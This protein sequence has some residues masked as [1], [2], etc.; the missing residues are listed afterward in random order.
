MST[1][2]EQITNDSFRKQL[3][4][5][6]VRTVQPFN[7]VENPAFENFIDFV[8]N[9]NPELKLPSR[10]TL[11][12]DFNTMYEEEKERLKF[13]IN[14]ND[15]KIALIID[16]WTSSNQHSF[17]GIIAQWISK[18]WEIIRVPLDLT[19]MEGSHSGKNIAE[20]VERAIAEFD[21]WGKI[22]GITTDNASN[23]DTFFEEL[24]E[25][26]SQ[27]GCQFDIKNRR[28]RCLAHILNLTTKSIRNA[29]AV[30][31]SGLVA[32]YSDDSSD[33]PLII[34]FDEDEIKINRILKSVEERKTTLGKLR[35]AIVG[36]RASP[37]RRQRFK[38]QCEV[39]GTPHKELI[40]DVPVRW[41]TSLGMMERG[42][43]LRAPLECTINTLPELT[44]FKLDHEDWDRI[45]LLIDILEPISK[46]TK[47]LSSGSAPT[48]SKCA[49]VYQDL[50]DHL[51]SF[52]E[53][54]IGSTSLGPQRN[55]AYPV[56]LQ[57]AARAGLGKL[58]KYYPSTDGLPYVAGT[59]L[60]PRCKS[61]WFKAVNWKKDWIDG[62]VRTFKNEWK[63]NY[64]LQE[65]NPPD[66]NIVDDVEFESQTLFKQM[67]G[68]SASAEE[69][70]VNRYLK[71]KPVSVA[72]MN[73][74]FEIILGWWKAHEQQF[75]R[76]SKMARD[77]LCV[78]GT[79]VPCE[80]FFSGA[81]DLLTVRR[82]R[83]LSFTIKQQMCLKA[84]LAM[85]D[86][87]S[88]KV[89]EEMFLRCVELK[90]YGLED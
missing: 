47:V 41:N 86:K 11:K 58:R 77:L 85:R 37:Q 68:F 73:T 33:G 34:D 12:K 43:E 38:A 36:I 54:P 88:R 84:W 67:S 1:P 20:T 28:V 14:T 27:N 50:F 4:K 24:G 79:G 69:D 71:E 44:A 39:T 31:E 56:W 60:D 65:L 19:L 76:L 29:T 82:Q 16:G 87:E 70:E 46:F 63:R 80:Q 17:L 59:I 52:I 45:N 9:G 62:S 8:G 21:L 42:K 81:P 2:R 30:Q 6:T 72:L 10:K 23:L 57:N 22:S 66:Q 55:H 90:V 5:L 75:P 26:M 53:V 7:L 40:L 61:T 15:S 78:S 13:A 18:D 74:K 49:S 3:V 89:S 51:D 83:L 35:H 25:L 48:I 32:N 64:K